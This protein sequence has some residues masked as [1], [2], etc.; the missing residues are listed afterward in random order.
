MSAETESIILGVIAFF[1][2]VGTAVAIRRK[3]AKAA[4]ACCIVGGGVLFLYGNLDHEARHETERSE[5]WRE[6][7][8][9][10]RASNPNEV[11]DDP[12]TIV[13]PNGQ[14]LRSKTLELNIEGDRRSSPGD[15]A[16]HGMRPLPGT[17]GVEGIN[18]GIPQRRRNPVSSPVNPRRSS[19]S[20][21]APTPAYDRP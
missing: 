1:A 5:Q 20:E 8:E 13:S 10:W 9:R 16:H 2:A 4:V 21:E 3:T 12:Q 11:Q 18:G 14:V 15:A 6:R 7:Q 19:P 17:A